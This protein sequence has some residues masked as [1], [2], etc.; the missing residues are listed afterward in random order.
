MA[1]L[2]SVFCK[3]LR[4]HSV[5]VSFGYDEAPSVLEFLKRRAERKG[6]RRE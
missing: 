4:E 2:F 6:G 5:G 3:V 1:F